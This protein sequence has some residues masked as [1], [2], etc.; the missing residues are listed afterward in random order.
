MRHPHGLRAGA[1]RALPQAIGEFYEGGYFAGYISHTADGVATHGL[2]VAPRATGAT[3]TGYPLTTN[4]ALKTSNTATPGTTSPFDGEAN[5][6]AMIAAGAAAHPAAQFCNNLNIGGYTDWYLPARFELE[7][8]YYNLKPNTN[9]N[10]TSWGVNDYSVPK[11]TSNYTA[12]NPAQTSVLAFQSGGGE[13][14]AL[15]YHY[16]ST[17]ESAIYGWRADFSQGV[18]N[19]GA[20][21]TTTACVRAFRRFAL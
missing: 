15:G 11:R 19:G 4:L 14:F 2:I 6:A 9:A 1:G 10:T 21:K 18:Q 7:I 3:G 13:E 17:E 8:S 12:G 20:F 16:T 5:T